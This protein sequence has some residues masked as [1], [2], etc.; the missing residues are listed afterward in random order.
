MTRGGAGI[1]SDESH[2]SNELLCQCREAACCGHVSPYHDVLSH[3]LLR[4]MRLD[5]VQ[6]SFLE[7]DDQSKVLVGKWNALD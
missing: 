6:L 2:I 3:R 5:V 1:Q 7:L 4:V